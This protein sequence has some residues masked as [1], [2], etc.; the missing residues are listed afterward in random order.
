M[1]NVH[2]LKLV[3]VAALVMVLSACQA[4]QNADLPANQA[5]YDLIG[6][7]NY[8]GTPAPYSLSIGDRISVQVF[9]EPDLSSENLEIDASGNIQFPLIGE[10]RAAGLTATSLS[11]AI[12]DR[13]GERYIRY[14][15]VVV[16][17]TQR[18]S[19]FVTVEGEVREPGVYEVDRRY[20]LLSALARAKSPTTTARIDQI[21]V[22]R[23]I[24]NQRTGAMFDLDAIREGRSPDP[25]ILAGDTIVVGYSRIRGT[26]R[27]ILQAAPLFNVFRAF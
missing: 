4:A 9:Q 5:A 2:S 18:T 8:S 24:N 16:S 3:F 13:L 21:V 22:F 20:T 7:A 12:E 1:V 14:P 23:T 27:E 19:S 11:R 25:Q 17:V 15:R 6:E 10:L 26:Y